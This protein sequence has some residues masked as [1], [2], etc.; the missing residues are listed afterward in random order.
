MADPAPAGTTAPAI[1]ILD[2]HVY[3]AMPMPCKAC[4]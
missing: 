1:E 2:L 3:T 4:P